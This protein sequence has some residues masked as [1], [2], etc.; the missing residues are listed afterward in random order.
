MKAGNDPP[1]SSV[2][3][4]PE[5]LNLDTVV[6]LECPEVMGGES[7]PSKITIEK[8]KEVFPSLHRPLGKFSPEGLQLDDSLH[9]YMIVNILSP[10]GSSSNMTLGESI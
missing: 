2:I 6:D 3:D 4:H 10:S 1:V 8:G 7:L 9:A 5:L